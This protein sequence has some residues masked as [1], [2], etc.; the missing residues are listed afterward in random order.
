MPRFNQQTI[1]HSLA[2]SLPVSK[3]RSQWYGASDVR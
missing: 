1:G 3:G 2:T